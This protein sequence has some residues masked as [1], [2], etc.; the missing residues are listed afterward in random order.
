MNYPFC[1]ALSDPGVF[2]RKGLTPRIS[3]PEQAQT[4]RQRQGSR[5]RKNRAASIG[6]H[7][8][9][10]LLD[11]SSHNNTSQNFQRRARRSENH[12]QDMPGVPVKY[13]RATRAPRSESFGHRYCFLIN[14]RFE[15]TPV[16]AIPVINVAPLVN[17]QPEQAH[18]VA[19]ALGHACRAVGFFIITGHGV[20]PALPVC[21]PASVPTG[22]PNTPRSPGRSSFARGWSRLMRRRRRD[23]LTESAANK[24]GR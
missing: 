6:L 15:E 17:G 23:S 5:H 18:A 12:A 1:V 3:F 16:S 8:F 24:N 13:E 22:R 20:P 14:D 9:K 7:G 4:A 11:H 19:N 2:E 10:D 21:R